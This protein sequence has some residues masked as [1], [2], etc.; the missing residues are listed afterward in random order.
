M[1]K[2]E[3]DEELMRFQY[4]VKV[5]RVWFDAQGLEVSDGLV[6]RLAILLRDVENKDVPGWLAT[7]SDH[8]DIKYREV[9]TP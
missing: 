2:K 5:A 7:Y 8:K 9:D 6:G 4:F 1:S 3:K